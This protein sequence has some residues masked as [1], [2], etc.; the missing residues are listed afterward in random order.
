MRT[1]P[2]LGL[3]VFLLIASC[4]FDQTGLGAASSQDAPQGTTADAPAGGT[5]DAKQSGTPDARVADA[6]P[7]APDASPFIGVTCGTQT[8]T[9]SDVCCVPGFGGGN[10]GPSCAQQ[11]PAGD[12]P[13]ACDGPEDCSGGSVCCLS[14][15]GSSCTDA[16]S[17][18]GFNGGSVA[19]RSDNDCSNGDT[20]CPVQGTDVSVCSGFCL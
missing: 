2:R 14:R 7:P 10:T 12:S 16:N 5:P 6:P 13:Y 19:C 1:P 8:C 4:S 15:S 17:C 18:G 3:L 9:G 11:C 20:C